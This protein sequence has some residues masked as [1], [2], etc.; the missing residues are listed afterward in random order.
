MNNRD[1]K[2]VK[3]NFQVGWIPGIESSCKSKYEDCEF[4]QIFN[5]DRSTEISTYMY[6]NEVVSLHKQLQAI[7]DSGPIN[8]NEWPIDDKQQTLKEFET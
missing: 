2:L 4:Q 1:D 5:K 8:T 3:V 6:W 7:L